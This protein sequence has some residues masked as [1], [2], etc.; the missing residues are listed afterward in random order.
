MVGSNGNGK[1]RIKVTHSVS[2]QCSP[3]GTMNS[4]KLKLTI[5]GNA[6]DCSYKGNGSC[7]S[8]CT[9][10]SQPLIT[11]ILDVDPNS[12]SGIRI[13]YSPGSPS[14]RHDLY[15]DGVRVVVGYTS[16]SIYNPQDALSHGYTI[17]AVNLSDYCFTD[18]NLQT[19]TDNPFTC[20]K[21]ST[22]VIGTIEDIS[23]CGFG[24]NIPFQAGY[25]ATRN[26]LYVNGVLVQSSVISP[27]T[28]YPSNSNSNSYK[29]RSIYGNESCYTDSAISNFSDTN[30]SVGIPSN[31]TIEDIE[32]CVLSGIKIYWN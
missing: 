15:K 7:L 9:N 4:W 18:S 20:L 8:G 28:Y 11:Q 32:P 24:I 2:G 3:S 29:I 25:P 10:P 17:R 31:I 26:D 16:G 21:P 6:Y 19:F 27:I 12:Q 5:N 1:W 14:T 13:Y 23:P 22:P 30:Q